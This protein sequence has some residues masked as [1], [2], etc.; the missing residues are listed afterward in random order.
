MLHTTV[1][2]LL[3]VGGPPSKQVD[4]Y[5]LARVAAVHHFARHGS[6]EHLQAILDKHPRLVDALEPLPAGHKPVATEGYTPLEWAAHYGHPTIAD[7]LMRGQGQSRQ[8]P[9]LDAAP[10][11][12]RHGNLAVVKLL[13]E[14]GADATAKTEAVPESSRSFGDSPAPG[15]SCQLNARRSIRPSRDVR[16]WSGPRQCIMQ[17]SLPILNP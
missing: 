11:R 3:L 6:L 4:P 2:L 10:R 13:I 5:E 9:R 16:P 12:A 8:R 15:S 17:R 14:H 7:Y 1:I